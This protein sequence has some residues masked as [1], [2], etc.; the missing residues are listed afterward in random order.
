MHNT[1]IDRDLA[2]I[3]QELAEAVRLLRIIAENEHRIR[4]VVEKDPAAKPPTKRR[5]RAND[6]KSA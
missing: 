3:K 2:V 6:P 1:N 4:C 5:G